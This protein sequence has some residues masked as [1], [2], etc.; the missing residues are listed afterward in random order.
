MASKSITLSPSENLF[1]KCVLDC[2]KSMDPALTQPEAR[3]TGGWV[4][5]KLLDVPSHDI[6]VA[7]ST[8]TGMQFVYLLQNFIKTKGAQYEEQAAKLG[9]KAELGNIHKVE[10][11][12]EKS[13]HL[14]TA[15]TRLFGFELDF[16]NLRKESYSE[17]SRNPQMEFGSPEEDALRRDATVNA[18][19]YNLHT[20]QIEDF[21]NQGLK[22]MDAKVIR[23]PLAPYQ[24][25]KDDPLR[26]LRLIRFASRLGYEIEQAS[27]AAMK[28]QSIHQALRLKISRERV[29]TEVD[30][31]LSGPDPHRA[32]ML[33]HDLDLY[34]S[35]F[36][37]PTD[38][39]VPPLASTSPRIYDGLHHLLASQD[40]A[41][42]RI[43][44]VH[45]D[46]SLCWYLAAYAA[47]KDAP[48]DQV[49]EAA[50]KGIDAPN[51]TRDIIGAAVA[52]RALILD[53]VA[54]TET[55]TTP[56]LRSSIGMTLRRLG[57][58]WRPQFIYA[59]LC[60]LYTT[61]APSAVEKFGALLRYIV[62]AGLEDVD[63]LAGVIDGRKIRDALGGVA[64]GPWMKRATDMVME[65]QLDHPEGTREEAV[66]MIVQRR[67]ELGV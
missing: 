17:T 18:L 20:Q 29:R 56:L 35:V 7:L 34:A 51:K 54:R 16:V 30:K 33:I 37:N 14:E 12:P 24:T 57:P 27:Q 43:L 49:K 1:C 10:A 53:L 41:L 62:A 21:T 28:D 15:T 2:I 55:T 65:W 47:W 45:D 36:A 5:D 66:E 25:F 31:M 61:N 60:E 48:A 26:V 52:N 4:R 3:I 11:N 64:G 50:R 6:D 9:V 58:T 42:D 13:K 44:H 67:R 59:L 32:M 46:P 19:F 23:T 22:D 8:M 40:A 38:N 63:T 39:F